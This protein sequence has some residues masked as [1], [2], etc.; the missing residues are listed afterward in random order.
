[1][2]QVIRGMNVRCKSREI[3]HDCIGLHGLMKER[4]IPIGCKNNI[5]RDE[6]W[7]RDDHCQ[8]NTIKDENIILHEDVELLLMKKYDLTY[9]I[10]HNIATMAEERWKNY[11]KRLSLSN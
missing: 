6:L 1:M 11:Q 7:I 10:A 4:D 9:G 3:L 8:Q 5:P 2:N